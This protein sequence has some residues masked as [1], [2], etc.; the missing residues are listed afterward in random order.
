MRTLLAVLAVA[1][2]ATSAYG[3]AI[4]LSWGQ[5]PPGFPPAPYPDGADEIWPIASDWAYLDVWIHLDDTDSGLGWWRYAITD[6]WVGDPDAFTFERVIPNPGT[7]NYYYYKYY[8]G[9]PY[10]HRAPGVYDPYFFKDFDYFYPYP[11]YTHGP[12]SFHVMTLALHCTGTLS[13]GIF[14]VTSEGGEGFVYDADFNG[15]EVTWGDTAIA[16]IPEP[17]SL[18]LLALGGLLVTTRRR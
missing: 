17:T 2:F 14:T 15:L 3:A 18:T 7:F 5:A 13:D 1:A 4:T 9:H 11:D 6:D 8:Q 16:H 12:A 10:G